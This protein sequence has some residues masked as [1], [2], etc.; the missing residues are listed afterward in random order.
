VSAIELGK[1]SW[2]LA[3]REKKGSVNHP[4]FGGGALSTLSTPK[5]QEKSPAVLHFVM[6]EETSIETHARRKKKKEG[7]SAS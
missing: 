2:I 5:T 4:A 7:A 6:K 1:L 3:E